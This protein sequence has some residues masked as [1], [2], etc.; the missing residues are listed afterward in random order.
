MAVNDMLMDLK[1]K[2]ID[3]EKTFVNKIGFYTDLVF[4][5]LLQ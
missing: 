2:Q 3:F 1:S 4:I 5:A